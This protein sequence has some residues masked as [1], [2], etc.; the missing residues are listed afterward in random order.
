MVTKAKRCVNDR[1]RSLGDD[2]NRTYRKN[3]FMQISM[4]SMLRIGPHER[5]DAHNHREDRA[6]A[7]LSPPKK[8]LS[9]GHQ[10]T[11]AACSS[12]R[13][14]ISAKSAAAAVAVAA[15]EAT[16]TAAKPYGPKNQ[17]AVAHAGTSTGSPAAC[18][19]F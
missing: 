8:E 9:G 15:N 6:V 11:T 1:R 13:T 3:P 18:H 5:H 7:T 19:G 16:T 2:N 12:A 17:S 4:V 14:A 10:R